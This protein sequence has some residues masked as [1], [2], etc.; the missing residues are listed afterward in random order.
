MKLLLFNDKPYFIRLNF[1]KDQQQPFYPQQVNDRPEMN[2]YQM[3]VS[4]IIG[5]IGLTRKYRLT[6]I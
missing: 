5:L 4:I 1:I 2:T 6:L 3:R